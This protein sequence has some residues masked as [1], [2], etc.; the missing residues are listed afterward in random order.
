M[1]KVAITRTDLKYFIDNSL[2]K[3]KEI[4]TKAFILEVE[5]EERTIED[6]D[7]K[8]HYTVYYKNRY[9]DYEVIVI[10]FG[11]ADI[12]ERFRKYFGLKIDNLY[13]EVKRLYL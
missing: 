7:N 1:K 10:I 9:N 4:N 3:N 2:T 6:I 11:D 12:E 5:I 13:K 8:K